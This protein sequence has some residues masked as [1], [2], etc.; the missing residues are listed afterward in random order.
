MTQPG[1]LLARG[2]FADV[3]AWD[4]GHVLKLYRAGIDRAVV[5]R[6]VANARA[7]AETGLATP[8]VVDVIEHDGRVGI[9]IRRVV[10]STMLAALAANP[11]DATALAERFAQLHVDVHGREVA[12]LPDQRATLTADVAR[13]PDVPVNV[14][15]AARSRLATLPRGQA[16][17]HGDFHPLNVI[18]AAD[19]LWIVDWSKATRGHPD[20]DIART[21]MLLRLTN[22]PRDAAP[23]VRDA[24]EQ[25]RATF[26]S[27][28]VAAYAARRPVTMLDAMAW[29]LPVA[30]ARLARE[31]SDNEREQLLALASELAD[32]GASPIFS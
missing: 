20:A 18:I 25:M 12:D 10:G 5:D 32:E 8:D 3:L 4:D 9:V 1:P 14:R 30:V 23:A 22:V 31:I 27:D 11:H 26:L 19:R 13:A 2:R 7:V 21:V 28:Y 16:I 15:A 24:A 29:M 6:E 17:C